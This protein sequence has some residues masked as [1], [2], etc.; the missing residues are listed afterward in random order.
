MS[1]L[2]QEQKPAALEKLM[3]VAE[4]T[5]KNWPDKPEADDARM[6]RGQAKLVVGQVR[7]AIDIFERVNPKSERYA[8]GHVLG[9]A[10]LLAALRD[11]KDE[12]HAASRQEADGRRPR[13]G[14]RMPRHRPGSLQEAVRAGQ[15]DAASTCSNRSFCWRRST[16]KAETASRPPRCISRWS[17]PSRPR[18]R[19]RS[20]PTRSASFSAPC[21]RTA[22]LDELDKAGEASDVL[23]ELGPDTLQV[24]DVLVEF[25]KLLNVER[26][27][28]DAR[29]TELEDTRQYEELNAAKARLTSV[30][31]LLGKTL[32]KLS[33]RQEL[34]LGQMMFIGETLNAIGMTDRGEPS[35]FRRSSNARKPTRVRQARRE[36]HEPDS[37]RIAQGAPQ[38]GKV[39][40]SAEAGGPTHQGESP[41]LGAADGEGPNSG[42]LGGKRPR[43][44]STRPWAIGPCFGSGCRR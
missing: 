14:H 25:A 35:S 39:R 32:V 38:A 19:K 15:A 3:K 44:S 10:E 41:G 16:A 6:A 12:A 31:D 29:V 11:G 43:P 20:T 17:T 7:E 2:P 1:R 13:Q 30:Q 23:I 33:Q 40:R 28:A 34:G 8:D 37:H 27:K 9:R 5:E 18:S 24:N 42:S 4:F 21:G 22:A 36:G 26:R